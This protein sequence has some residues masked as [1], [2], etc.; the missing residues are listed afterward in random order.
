LNSKK[1][2]IQLVIDIPCHSEFE[3]TLSLTLSESQIKH[4]EQVLSQVLSQVKSNNTS[5]LQGLANNLS[6]AMSQ[7][8]NKVMTQAWTPHQF[9]IILQLM[10]TIFNPKSMKEI[11]SKMPIKNRMRLMNQY[12]KPLL[13]TKIAEMTYPESSRH[14]K[15]QYKLTK[16]GFSLLSNN[17]V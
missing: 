9:I 16:K 4:L 8:L 6:Q 17:V 11:V 13:E 5:D 2:G 12:L 1:V 15:Q 14:P 10:I 7:V 3:S